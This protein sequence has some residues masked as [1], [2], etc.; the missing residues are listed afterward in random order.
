M[1]PILKAR[2]K[3]FWPELR[4]YIIEKKQILKIISLSEKIKTVAAALRKTFLE[5]ETIPSI[6]D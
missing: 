4:R 2:Q 3:Y 1:P 6:A 5:L